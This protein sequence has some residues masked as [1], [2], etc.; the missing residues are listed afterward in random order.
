[1]WAEEGSGPL[2]TKGSKAFA[3]IPPE[4]FANRKME[5]PS[6]GLSELF[7]K[8]PLEPRSQDS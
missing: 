1:V 2:G 5:D 6:R 8:C 3:H 7:E 4:D